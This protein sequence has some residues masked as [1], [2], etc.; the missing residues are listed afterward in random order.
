MQCAALVN[1]NHGYVNL[2]MN[3]Y[4]YNGKG[5]SI[6]SSGQI[7]W[8]KNTV[9]DESVIVG[10]SQCITSLDGYS[11]PLKCTGSLMYLSNLRKPADEELVEYPSVHLTSI[12]DWDPSVL[13]FRYP[14]GDGEP[15]C[16]CDPQHVDLIV[17]NFDH[18][19]LY[20]KRAVGST[21]VPFVMCT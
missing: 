3:E 6:H 19:R 21:H 5:H 14:E 12:H 4:A 2:I 8:H 15:L 7:A 16:A 9:D 17:P 11:F 1:T 20:T 10:G 18:Q 13:D